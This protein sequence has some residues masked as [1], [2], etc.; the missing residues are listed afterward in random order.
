LSSSLAC[1]GH[2]YSSYFVF[3]FLLSFPTFFHFLLVV[4]T[5]VH[6]FLEINIGL[7]HLIWPCTNLSVYFAFITL[8][9]SNVC[10][11]VCL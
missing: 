8:I 7:V 4:D 10:L 9:P 3:L 11:F 1:Y 6:C 2:S 5:L